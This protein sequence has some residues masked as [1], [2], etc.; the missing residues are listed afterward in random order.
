MQT[1]GR[2]RARL[3]ARLTERLQR[4]RPEIEET[5]LAR[6]YSVSDPTEAGDPEYVAGLR[7][8]VS[9]AIDY[10]L[11]AVS[12]TGRLVAPIPPVLLAQAR[13]AARSGVSLDTVLRRYFAGYTLLGE[14]VMQ[15]AEAERQLEAEEIHRLSKAQAVIF[16]QLVVGVTDAY[17]HEV[18]GRL[19]S[20][21]RDQVKRVK[22]LMA[23]ELVDSAELGYELDGHHLGVVAA[24]PGA[25]RTTRALATALD[26]RLLLVSRGE[27]ILWGWLG[28]H[29]RLA[30]T[31]VLQLASRSLPAEVSLAVGESTQGVTGWRLT[32][33]QAVA[34]LP[35]ALR[36]SHRLV[37]Y[38]DVALLASALQD[39]VLAAS[40]RDIY[41]IPLEEG[42]GDGGTDLRDTLTAYFKAGRNAS[43]AASALGLNRKTVS[44]RLREIEERIGRSLEECP[45]D[46]EV[47][48]KLRDLASPQESLLPR[49]V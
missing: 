39:D 7:A 49:K 16:D 44:V 15:E 4:R 43:S 24:G 25:S 18:E 10:G 41:L 26:R 5:I 42:R 32:H 3:R 6:V 35:V 20:V 46:L 13:H 45:A 34:A 33:R 8:A 21:E 2:P 17:R 22:G 30:A 37:R 40:L 47:A 14:F 36:G 23:G 28:G 29:R 12:E 27:G 1:R 19:H 48:L 9:A 11:S 38:A 31:E